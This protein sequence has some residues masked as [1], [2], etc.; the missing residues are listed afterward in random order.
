MAHMTPCLMWRPTLLSDPLLA[1]QLST[2]KARE[3]E[4]S[5]FGGLYIYIAKGNRT[6]KLLLIGCRNTTA[7]METQWKRQWK[8][9]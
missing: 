3:L 1:S 4:R 2:Q 7:I 9:K 8:M 6:W 5:G